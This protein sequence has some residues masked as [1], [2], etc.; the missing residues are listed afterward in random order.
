[1]VYNTKL[2]RLLVRRPTNTPSKEGPFNLVR[3][4]NVHIKVLSK[5]PDC[6]RILLEMPADE[7]NVRLIVV[8][9]FLSG[10]TVRN[11]ADG[12]YDDL[13][14]DSSLDML[15]EVG[16]E[17]GFVFGREM[18]FRMITSRGNVEEIDAVIGEDFCE[19]YTIVDSP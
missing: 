5:L 16:V 15:R 12:A 4:H 7:D 9:H 10:L 17:G 11:A 19:L 3:H 13:V 1:M 8:E 6:T 2:R 18:L 14:A